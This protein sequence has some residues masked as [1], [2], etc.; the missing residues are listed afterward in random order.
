M[1]ADRLVA[2]LLFLQARGQAHERVTAAEV[3]AELEVS[4]RTARRDLEALASAGVPVY[5]QPRRGG[6]WS[7]VG[8][9][10][11][12]LTGLTAGEIRALFLVAGPSSVHVAGPS[13]VHVAGDSTSPSRSSPTPG[14]SPPPPGLSTTPELRTALRKLVRALPA[15]FRP[16]AEAASKAGVT[17]STDW[18]RSTVTA[19]TPHLDALQRAVVDGIQIRLGYAR[20]GKPAG[21]R[22][23]HPLGLASKA[24][25]G[26]LVADTDHGLRT[27]RLSR[28]TSVEPTGDPVVRPEGFDLAA[29]WRSLATRMEDRMLAATVRGRAE[30]SAEPVLE[31]LFGGRLR[32]GR[33]LPDGWMEIEVDGPSPEVVAAQL[34]GLGARVEVLDPPQARE[35]LAR[36][37]AELAATYGPP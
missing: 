18:S 33:S 5:S 25:V 30:R 3:A 34:A 24:G 17:D 15:T 28:V 19:S 31:G 26:Y 8:G 21:E 20:P 4:E 35:R 11:T 32:T 2:T 1:R 27:F 9:A 13:S 10:R 14:S 16:G 6:G 22:T 23:V 29:A 36:L 37:A 7:L 12:D